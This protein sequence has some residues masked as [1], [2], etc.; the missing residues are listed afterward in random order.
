MNT[1]CDRSE[2]QRTA[3]NQRVELSRTGDRQQIVEAAIQ[4]WFTP[5][6]AKQHPDVLQR[7]RWRMAEN[8]NDAYARAYAVF[9]T[10]DEELV[11]LIS[12]IVTPTLVITGEDDSNST[13]E[14]AHKLASLL[15]NGQATILA[16]QRHMTPLEA[17]EELSQQ[18]L[19]FLCSEIGNSDGAKG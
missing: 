11:P 17:P 19:G 1:V 4:R 14:M 9:A 15:P 5:Q 2:A 16:R 8:D 7:M 6:F 12:K 13:P 18:I 3:V 10:A